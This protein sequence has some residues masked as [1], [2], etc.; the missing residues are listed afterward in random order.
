MSKD[1]DADQED[2]PKD[3]KFDRR[4]SKLDTATSFQG[5]LD[6]LNS[7]RKNT[8]TKKNDIVAIAE[9][10]EEPDKPTL[11]VEE[12]KEPAREPFEGFEGI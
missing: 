9:D 5:A 3:R 7:E 1:G 2:D 4:M 8:K 11:P 10:E 6:K 12:S